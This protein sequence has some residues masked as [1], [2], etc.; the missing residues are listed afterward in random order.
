MVR[1]R[2]HARVENGFLGNAKVKIPLPPV[3]EQMRR[4]A[5]DGKQKQP[6]NW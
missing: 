5:P 3:L 6:M 1:G 4:P 2:L